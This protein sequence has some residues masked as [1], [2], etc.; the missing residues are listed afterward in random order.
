MPQATGLA[1]AA[2]CGVLLLLLAAS[3]VL[4]LQHVSN[5]SYFAQTKN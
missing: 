5:K 1:V 3:A 4:E 2:T